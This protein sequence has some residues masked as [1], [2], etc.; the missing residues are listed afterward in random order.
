MSVVASE[1]GGEGV[2]DEEGWLLA[3]LW[4]SD[5]FRIGHD[6]GPF[7]REKIGLIYPSIRR[8]VNDRGAFGALDLLGVLE[9]LLGAGGGGCVIT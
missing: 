8:N 6:G 9:P 7:R 5:I 1:L 3:P 2:L 4:R